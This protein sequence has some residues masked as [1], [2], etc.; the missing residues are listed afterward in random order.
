MCGAVALFFVLSFFCE[1][2]PP[3]LADLNNGKDMSISI[4]YYAV[5]HA[6]LI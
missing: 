3:D 1:E 4:L 6:T 2:F 5:F